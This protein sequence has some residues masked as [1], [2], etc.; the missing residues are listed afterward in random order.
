MTK[1]EVL[2]AIDNM[3]VRELA[4]LVEAICERYGVSATAVAAPPAPTAA[5]PQQEE[6]A[7]EKVALKVLLKTPGQQKVQV[8]KK[9]RE[10]TGKGLK[11]CKEIVD[12]L[13]GLIKDGLDEEEANK[14]KAQLEELGAEVELK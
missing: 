5:K 8:I 13:P 2:E 1:E 10:I 7:E 12:N 4:E 9:I 3:S 11:E 14:I 6:V